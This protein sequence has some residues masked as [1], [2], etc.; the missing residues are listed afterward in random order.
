MYPLQWQWDLVKKHD[1]DAS[2]KGVALAG[3]LGACSPMF[4][5]D[6]WVGQTD[7]GDHP[8]NIVWGYDPKNLVDSKVIFL[9]YA[10]AL[11]FN[12]AWTKDTW[13][14]ITPAPWPPKL[15]SHCNRVALGTAIEKINAL[16]EDKIRDVV[17]R[18]HD[19][20]MDSAQ[21]AVVADALVGRRAG[22]AKAL[23]SYLGSSP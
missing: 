18:V 5:F 23:N 13:Q 14:T 2:P 12:G 16:S 21:R 9:D 6:T 22:L 10:N 11:G 3:V 15:V 19:D 8:S 20:F 4:A 7:H 1:V 17:N